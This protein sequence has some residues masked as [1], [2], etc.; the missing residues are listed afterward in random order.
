MQTPKLKTIILLAGIGLL[1]SCTKNSTTTK[2]VYDTV[3]LTKTDTIRLAPP[4]DT[5][6]LT[7]GLVLYLP[8][9][10]GSY[11]DSSGLNNV[12]TAMN[13]AALGYDMHGYAQ[14]AF[15]ENGNGA[16]LTVAN[17]GSYA[18]DTAFSVS[19]DFMIRSY[20]Y[21]SG[22]GNYSGLECFLSIASWSTPL[23]S[24]TF[25][26]GFTNPDA[27][28]SFNFT[29]NG[30]NAVCDNT[31]PNPGNFPDTTSFTPQLG[32]WYNATCTYTNGIASTYINGQLIKSQRITITDSALFCSDGVFIVGGV[33]GGGEAING[34][35][36]NVRF[37][38]RTLN[39]QQIAWLSRNFQINSTNQKPGL[40]HRK[41]T[42][43]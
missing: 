39:A 5:P 13:G 22:N 21:Y 1:A 7:N 40:L 10:N 4:D 30:S 38:N 33:S 35:V 29:V 26:V 41:S 25:Y 9:T 3:T 17:N 42:G 20:P 15:N 12:V 11:A 32:A 27:P 37:Y 23:T 36:D 19:L 2:I 8:F 18:V 14:S 16:V 34:E 28:T 24:G 43:F 31:A 6:N